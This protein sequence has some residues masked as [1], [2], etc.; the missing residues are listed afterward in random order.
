MA[1]KIEI[2]HPI[3]II[4]KIEAVNC[5]QDFIIANVPK[6]INQLEFL[7]G[8]KKNN[9]IFNTRLNSSSNNNFDIIPVINSIL[10]DYFINPVSI[11]NVATYYLNDYCY[12]I[13]KLYKSKHKHITYFKKQIINYNLIDKLCLKAENIIYEKPIYFSNM[14]TYNNKEKYLLL[15][16]YCIEDIIINVKIYK[17][18]F[19]FGMRI[20]IT[21]NKKIPPHKMKTI[22]D[23][24]KKMDLVFSNI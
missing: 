13:K 12:N 21:E 20:N 4:E 7:F 10:I 8:N 3:Q 6:S 1:T 11:Y 9:I 22:K 5:L 24:Y 17:T 2:T 15:E 19:T 14:K 16:W 23:I 18:Y